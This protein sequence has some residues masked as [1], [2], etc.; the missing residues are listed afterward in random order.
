[1]D[2]CPARCAW[3]RSLISLPSAVQGAAKRPKIRLLARLQGA[4]SGP[5][6]A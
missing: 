2:S 3:I 4:A 6:S 5:E 1:M